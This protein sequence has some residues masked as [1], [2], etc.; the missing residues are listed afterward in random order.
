MKKIISILTILVLAIILVGCGGSGESSKDDSNPANLVI[1]SGNPGGTYYYIG[2]G[3]S[4]ILS[5][6]LDGITVTTESTTGSPVE[7]GT[8]TSK[9]IDTLGIVTLDGTIFGIEGNKEK[10]FEKPLENLRMVQAGHNLTL[11]FVSLKESGID[12][13][14]DIKGKKIGLPTVGNT[15]Y[16]QALAILEEYGIT[17]DDVK[18][19]PMVYAEQADALKDGTIDVAIV[20]GGVPVAAV[21]DLDTTKNI[22]ILS[23]DSDKIDILNEK[24]PYW[25]ISELPAKTYQNQTE[26]VNVM[27]ARIVLICNESLSEEIV[28]NITKILNESTEALGEIHQ[29]G[30]DWNLENSLDIFDKQLVPFHEGAIKYYE[31]IRN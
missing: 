19:T 22:N 15:A 10:G 20:A 16:F 27:N 3:Q 12:N 8:F 24:Y 23:I 7:N 13:L 14:G 5:Q 29:N 9:S 30:K 4:K 25:A 21:T 11:Y 18:S 28:Y 6:K 17:L 2:A 1:C 26:S 31:E